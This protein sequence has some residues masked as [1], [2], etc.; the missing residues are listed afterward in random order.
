MTSP[1]RI[2]TFPT[3]CRAILEGV[4]PAA[5]TITRQVFWRWPISTFQ[6]LQP[7]QPS[8]DSREQHAD[9][10]G[11]DAE[12]QGRDEAGDLAV[13]GDAERFLARFDREAGEADRVEVARLLQP[14]E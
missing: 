10:A 3:P 8:T 9:G 2:R 5:M 14:A 1:R 12:V 4:P 7:L 6:S 13:E 11:A